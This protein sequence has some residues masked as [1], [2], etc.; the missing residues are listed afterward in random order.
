MIYF[1]LERLLSAERSPFDK[2]S[3]GMVEG[4]DLPP[5]NMVEGYDLPI[6]KNFQKNKASAKL[7]WKDMIYLPWDGGRI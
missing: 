5:Q 3:L 4:Y 6:S 7:W 1:V 2:T